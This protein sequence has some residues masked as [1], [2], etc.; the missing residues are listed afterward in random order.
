MKTTR[1]NIAA[2]HNILE[3]LSSKIVAPKTAFRLI[4]IKQAIRYEVEAIAEV[5]GTLAITPAIEVY[6]AKQREI[7]KDDPDYQKKSMAIYEENKELVDGYRAKEKEFN[8]MLDEEI[9]IEIP[10]IDVESLPEDVLT[11]SEIET[12]SSL[13]EEE[14]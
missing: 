5:Q 1:R 10:T 8:A 4:K 3:K 6:N 13:F 2:I 12:L 11:V 7:P 14:K 9:E